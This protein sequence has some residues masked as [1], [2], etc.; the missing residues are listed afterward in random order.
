MQLPLPRA[1]LTPR[2]RQALRN[3]QDGAWELGF[4]GKNLFDKTAELS[5]QA[6]PNSIYPL[7]AAP[8]G[9]DIVRTNRPRE[10]GVSLRYAFGSR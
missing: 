6:T 7:F 4:Y 2:W 5:R 9:Y 1:S 3:A 10:L 8:S